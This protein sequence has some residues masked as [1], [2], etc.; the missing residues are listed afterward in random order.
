MDQIVI[1]RYID[2]IFKLVKNGDGKSIAIFFYAFISVYYTDI[3]L[4]HGILY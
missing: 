1:P 4:Y 2:F 3:R